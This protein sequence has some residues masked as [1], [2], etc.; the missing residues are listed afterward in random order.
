M[1][2]T[3]LGSLFLASAIILSTNQLVNAQQEKTGLIFEGFGLNSLRI[4]NIN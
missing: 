3:I 4:I 1:E 2:Q